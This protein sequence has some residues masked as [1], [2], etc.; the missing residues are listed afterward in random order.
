MTS[1]VRFDNSCK[2]VDEDDLELYKALDNELSFQ[3]KGAEFSAAYQGYINESGEF[4]TWD[5]KRHLLNSNGKFP[6]GLLP[7]VQEFFS[8]RGIYVPVIDQRTL[9]SPLLELDISGNLQKLGKIPRPY[10][11]MAAETAVGTDRGIIRM[12]T[13]AGKCNSIDSLHITEN[14]LLDYKELLEDISLP[15]GCCIPYDIKVSTSKVFGETDSSSMI[16]RDGYGKS[17]KITTS[18]GYNLTATYNHKIQVIDKDG[19]FV[20]K[21]FLDLSCDDYA[22]ISYNNMMF[23][24]DQMSKDEA[25]WL[26]LLFGD[27]S[28]TLKH[29]VSFTNMDEHILN[30]VKLFLD[31]NNILY[32]EYNTKSKA[33]NINIYSLKYR[34]YLYNMGFGYEKSIHK[35]VPKHIRKLNEKSLAMFLRGIYETDGWVENKG[36]K[37][38][39]CLGLSNKKAIDQIH[40]LLANFGII[41]SRRLKKT[42]HQDS[43]ILTIYRDYIDVFNDRIG[44][45]PNGKKFK[46]IQQLKNCKHNSNQK[47]SNIKYRIK[48]IINSVP[49]EKKLCPIKWETVKSWLGKCAWREPS[50]ENLICLL[51]FII[52]RYKSSDAKYLLLQITDVFCDKI[53]K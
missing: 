41:A 11:I 24:N 22:L 36:S 3:I 47:I 25:Y 2:I 34:D 35:T 42:T 40:L 48:S 46:R 45:D 12:A 27:G 30:F 8:R 50:K 49:F 1:I 13:G 7:R 4:V 15:E 33:K 43:H 38:C 23:G 10:Q 19:N 16:Y 26:G 51:S 39:I 14:G 20:W 18:Y 28:L 44:F 32:K 37:I 5:G 53:K 21:K 9:R 52:N 6:V 31:N 17:L 29:Q